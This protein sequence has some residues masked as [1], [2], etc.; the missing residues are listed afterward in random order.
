MGSQSFHIRSAAV[1]GSG[2]M[3]GSIAALLAG[4]GIPVTL[5]DIAPSKLTEKEAARGLTLD[6]PEVRNRIVRENMAKLQ[7]SRPPTFYS[8]TD[9]DLISPGN[10]E[11][12]FEKLAVVDW[13]IEVIV[14]NLE[15][16]R[17]FFKRLDAIR[18]Q[19]QIVSSNTS[20]LPISELAAGHSDDFRRHFLGTHFFN[21]PRYLKLLELIPTVDT[22]PALLNFFREFA[23]RRLGKGVVLCKDTPN[24]IANRV[25]GANNGFRM[26]YGL[27]NGY[28]VEEVDAIAGPL[29]GYPKTAVF[30]LLDLVG[31]DVAQLVMANIAAV[32]PGDAAGCR[33]DGKM[34]TVM[35]SMVER[36]WLGNKTSIGFYKRMRRRIAQPL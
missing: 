13:V 21:P 8:R 31:L 26:S 23:P 17:G 35:E 22:D 30:R 15:I 6:E 27:E 19:G 10:L 2:T 12:D 7:K 32:L 4:V 36:E 18:P 20:G 14:E 28:A 25:G 16:K 29:M 5:L 33:G 9:E 1:V 11:D 3:G 24:F 34:G